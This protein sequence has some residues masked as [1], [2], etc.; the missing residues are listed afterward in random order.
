MRRG[1]HA[2]AALLAAAT[3][4]TT[5]VSEAVSEPLA[6]TRHGLGADIRYTEYGVP[7]I[8]AGDFTGLGYGFGFAAATD[9]ICQIARIYLTVD[10]QRSR[11][12]G[13]DTPSD[14]DYGPA[15]T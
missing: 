9:N 6:E 12:L 1:I 5:T 14:F 15:E 13:A 3:V 8:T 11:Y 7:H 2:V 10:A 4:L